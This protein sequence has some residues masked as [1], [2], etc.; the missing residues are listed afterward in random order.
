MEVGGTQASGLPL[1]QPGYYRVPELWLHFPI[2]GMGI[3]CV[4]PQH[5]QRRTQRLLGS[6]IALFMEAR[7]QGDSSLLLEHLGWPSRHRS[8]LASCGHCQVVMW[9]VV[10][11]SKLQEAGTRAAD[12]FGASFLLGVCPTEPWRGLKPNVGCCS[13]L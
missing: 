9:V 4:E 11:S 8:G 3:W 5:V 13:T 2:W 12:T 6:W 10:T 1:P 7:T